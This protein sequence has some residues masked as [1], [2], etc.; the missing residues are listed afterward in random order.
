VEHGE[1]PAVGEKRR[2]VE[3]LLCTMMDSGGRVHLEGIGEHAVDIILVAVEAELEL[4]NELTKGV[5]DRLGGVADDMEED[6]VVGRVEVVMVVVPIV[7]VDMDLDLADEFDAVDEQVDVGEV[8]SG[9]EVMPTRG[10][11][12]NSTT[13]GGRLGEGLEE[14]LLPYVVE[15]DLWHV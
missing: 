11:H 9:I 12:L 8:G 5:V 6:A 2:I 7:A 3:Q 1:F 4:G 14:A 10:E 13:V 15:D